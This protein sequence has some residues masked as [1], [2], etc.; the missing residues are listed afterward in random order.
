MSDL[1]KAHNEGCAWASL[2]SWGRAACLAALALLAMSVPVLGRPGVSVIRSVIYQH[3]PVQAPGSTYYNHAPTL[4]RLPDGTLV[5]AW[6]S[7]EREGAVDNK[8]MLARSTDDGNSWSEAIAVIDPDGDY[9]A[10]DP[11]LFY[12]SDRLWLMYRLQ[13]EPGSGPGS[14]LLDGYLAYSMDGGLTWS[15][16]FRMATGKDRTATPLHK[17]VY[18]PDGWLA[19]GF[20]WRNFDDPQ[21]HAGVL[22]AS[23]DLQTWEARGDI[24]LPGRRLLE[25]VLVRASDGTFLLYLRTDLAHIYRSSSLDEGMTWSEPQPLDVPNPDS[26]SDLRL[27]SDGRILA[28]WNNSPDARD[29]LSLGI[30]DDTELANL[31]QYVVLEHPVTL[32][33]AY[34][35]LV[36][37][38]DDALVAYSM[39]NYGPERYGDI[40]FVRYPLAELPERSGHLTAERFLI[41]AR[42]TLRDI[43]FATTETVWAVGVEGSIAHSV[44]GGQTWTTQTSGIGNTLWG[45][46]ALDDL[47]A[48]AV[49]DSSIILRTV[50]GGANWTVVYSRESRSL[51]ATTF[52]DGALG[53]AVG[54]S[55]I[56]WR[57]TDGGTSWT[58]STSP[59]T[60]TLRAVTFRDTDTSWAVGDAGIVLTSAD[61]GLSWTE[62]DNS[63]VSGTLWG[64]AF[65]K[66]GR[67]IIVGDNGLVFVSEDAG[68]TW[69]VQDVGTT[70]NLRDVTF[71]GSGRALVVSDQ[72]T[73][74]SSAAGDLRQWAKENTP[75][76]NVFY[77]LAVAE[78]QAWAAGWDGRILAFDWESLLPYRIL[79][80]LIMRN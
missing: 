52:V 47:T 10:R 80:P 1:T 78:D 31:T 3:D 27:L 49:G 71:T 63:G 18:L 5:A 14:R 38:G 66:Q 42:L 22:I 4:E 40:W 41:D 23:A 39:I 73:L 69:A 8:I 76:L 13:F 32:A 54:T 48:V 35:H 68:S 24:Y 67:G 11:L 26:L 70:E 75:D 58:R 61:A 62:V 36:L 46:A 65:D 6:F 29:Y 56:I 57:S 37:D 19:F 34:P 9:L 64:I 44:D 55:G 33:A 17:P 74:L 50:D 79:L 2:V 25:P 7:G 21:T 43:A 15:D 45:L 72:G 77:A 30:F 20:Y 51:Y 53:L 12:H 60:R 28:A 59:V 16:P